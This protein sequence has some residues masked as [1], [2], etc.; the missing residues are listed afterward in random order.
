[1][2]YILDA[3]RR[4][5]AQRSRG[6]LPGL[7]EAAA[8]GA[9]PVTAPAG[10]AR[11]WLLPLT[12]L[13]VLGLLA[14]AF[15]A[16][17]RQTPADSLPA[18]QPAADRVAPDEAV[19]IAGPASTAASEP[20]ALPRKAVIAEP[21]SAT[22]APAEKAIATQR[23]SPTAPSAAAAPGDVR[24]VPAAELPS[25]KDLPPDLQRSLPAIVVSGNVYSSDPSRRMLVVNGELWREGDQIGPDLVLE[26]IRRRDAVLRYRG[27][28][29]T[30]SP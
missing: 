4:A 21:R 7:H 12:L 2:S 16:L 6:R 8:A 20:L 5:E 24:P 11:R 18:R 9:L 14:A 19:A 15:W 27:T 28:R 30:V 29:F 23:A 10:A 22:A 26:Q 13:L 1:M 25:R 3:L 17:Q